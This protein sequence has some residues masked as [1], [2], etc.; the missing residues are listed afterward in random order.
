MGPIDEPAIV[1]SRAAPISLIYIKRLHEACKCLLN[2]KTNVV[3]SHDNSIIVS[4]GQ[5]PPVTSSGQSSLKFFH[6]IIAL[7]C[8]Q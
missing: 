8:L 5:P 6:A 1:T 3:L 4:N 7:L 2:N